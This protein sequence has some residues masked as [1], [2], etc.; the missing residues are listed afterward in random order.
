[1]RP[2][3]SPQRIYY[4]VKELLDKRDAEIHDALTRL[5]RLETTLRNIK[6]ILG[7]V[8]APLFL[9]FLVDRLV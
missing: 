4:D 2:G 9:A 1:M 6:W 7:L 5:D 3:D 8:V